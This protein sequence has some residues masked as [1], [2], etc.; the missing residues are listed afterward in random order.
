[1]KSLSIITNTLIIIYATVLL[2]SCS[3]L[4]ASTPDSK[5]KDVSVIPGECIVDKEL[6]CHSAFIVDSYYRFFFKIGLDVSNVVYSSGDNSY[7]P[8][9]DVYNRF[10]ENAQIVKEEYKNILAKLK[11]QQN[12]AIS[13]LF[14]Y[15]DTGFSLTADRDFAGVKAGDNLVSLFEKGKINWENYDLNLLPLQLCEQFP[16]DYMLYIQSGQFIKFDLHIGN[17][18]P[19]RETVTF[20]LT[21]PI[22]SV[23]FLTWLNDKLTDENA[24]M[25]WKDE[26]LTCTF[27]SNTGLRVKE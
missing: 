14:F 16:F 3:R 4:P 10:G 5:V 18:Q 7:E 23:Q 11:I 19:V 12:K 17:F 22:K 15:E 9:D 2:A 26:V 13:S 27:S 21:L 1:M 6:S 24:P 20:T 25:T 8:S